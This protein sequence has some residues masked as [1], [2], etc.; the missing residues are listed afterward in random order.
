MERNDVMSEQRSLRTRRKRKRK[1]RFFIAIIFLM[2]I[3]A[4]SYTGYEYMMGKQESQ[5]RVSGDDGSDIKLDDISSKY[6]DEFKGVDNNDGKTNVLLLGVDQRSDETPR[7]DTIMIAQYD[8]NGEKAKVASLMRDLYVNIPGHGYN[9]IN[10]A[11]AIGGPELM[12]Q[13]IK[14]NFGI[15]VEYYSIIDFDGFTHIV[16]TLAPNGVEVDV[17]KDMQ[18]KASDTNID[19]K[20]GTHDLNGEELLGYARYR[21]DSKGDF[22][23]VERQ[24]E[25]IKLLKDEAVSLNGVMKAP[26]LIGTLQPYI[27]TNVGSGKILDLGKDLLFNPVNDIET[28]SLPTDDNVRNERV[29]Y[30]IGLV[31][32]HDEEKSAQDIQEF[33]NE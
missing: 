18:Y 33:F 28:F 2:F 10:A 9:K 20:Q 29:D 26:R 12:R 3:T 25:V 5:G 17:E 7:S 16:D 15:D 4:I 1:K 30:P 13:T 24:Q 31:L 8:E 23:R 19:L 11:F 21:S 32:A 22:A 27:D 14:E 6:K